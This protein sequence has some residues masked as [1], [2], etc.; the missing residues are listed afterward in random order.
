M[1][2]QVF[3]GEKSFSHIVKLVFA[4]VA[5]MVIRGYAVPIVFCAFV[6]G[7]PIRFAWERVVRRRH[8]E[9]PVF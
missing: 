1:V 9:E 5:L 6:L 3:R 7:S 2:N 8:Q 4:L